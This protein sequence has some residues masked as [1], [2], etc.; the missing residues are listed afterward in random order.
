MRQRKRLSGQARRASIVAA[1]ASLFAARGFSGSTRE[2]AAGLGVTQA[3]LYR[4]F[5]TKAALVDAVFE[6]HRATLDPQAALLL[7]QHG[8][9]LVVRLQRFYAAYLTRRSDYA[10]VRLFMHASLSGI[11]YPLRYRDD[12]DGHVLGPVLDALRVEHGLDAAP[13]PLPSIERE[14]ALGLHGGIIFIGVRRHVYGAN[15]DAAYHLELVNRFI[16]C[17]LPGGLA[18]LKWSIDNL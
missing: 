14:L 10:G 4:Y 3:L 12:L 6:A 8:L 16:A 9:P 7:R 17:W 18:Q 13:R 1:A 2:I 11:D 15:I 5:P